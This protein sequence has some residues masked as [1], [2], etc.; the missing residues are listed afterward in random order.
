MADESIAPIVRPRASNYAVSDGILAVL[1]PKRTTDKN[2]VAASFFATRHTRGRARRAARMEAILDQQAELLRVGEELI[3]ESS[4]KLRDAAGP[5]ALRQAYELYRGFFE[6]VDWTEPWLVAVL[7]LHAMLLLVAL[8]FIAERLN[9]LASAHWRA[10]STQDYFDKEG[11]FTTTVFCVPLIA[12]LVVVLVNFLRLMASMMIQAKR[13]QLKQ[14]A[15]AEA[16][17]ER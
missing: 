2:V 3:R 1:E 17:K 5:D 6:A 15:R 12:V 11:V 14:R 7:S 9:G 16:K 8:V 10:F 13:A 4:R